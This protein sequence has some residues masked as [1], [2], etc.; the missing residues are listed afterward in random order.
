MREPARVDD[1]TAVRETVLGL[2]AIGAAHVRGEVSVD[3]YPHQDDAALWLTFSGTSVSRT[4]SSPRPADIYTTVMSRFVAKKQILFDLESGFRSGEVET[5]VQ[6]LS[7]ERSVRPAARGLRGRI[8]RRAA[9]RRL[10]AL[11]GYLN[12]VARRS[13]ERGIEQSFDRETRRRLVV[14]NGALHTLKVALAQQGVQLER[15]PYGVSL[16]TTDHYLQLGI[17]DRDAP[18]PRLPDED[19][20]GNPVQVWLH[21]SLVGDEVGP[22]VENWERLPS[23]LPTATNFS[24]LTTLLRW[25]Q[26]SEEALSLQFDRAADWIVIGVGEGGERIGQAPTSRRRF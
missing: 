11:D 8:V 10:E 7:T 26:P 13:V 24:G 19:V 5:T 15:G 12:Q 1:T 22:L 2:A 9:H 17:G 14:L 4:V 25:P 6:V 18:G 20:A 3:L 16:N 23:L 21:T